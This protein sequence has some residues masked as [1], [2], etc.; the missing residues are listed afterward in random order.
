[1]NTSA[2]NNEVR[3][4]KFFVKG[5]HYRCIKTVKGS[6]TRGKVYE[7][8]SEAT[9]HYGWLANNKGEHHCWPQPGNI[10][11]QCGKWGFAPEDIDPREYFEV[12]A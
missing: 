12:I 8:C 3:E 1:M 9:E 6:F 2:N 10:S 4:Q 5:M 11:D 7:Q